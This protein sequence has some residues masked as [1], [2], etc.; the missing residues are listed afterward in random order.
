M[1]GKDGA[2]VNKEALATTQQR[3]GL[4]RVT[5]DSR[6]LP[7]QKGQGSLP[8]PTSHAP[9]PGAASTPREEGLLPVTQRYP[10][11]ACQA[12]GF[13]PVGHLFPV[14]H[15]AASGFPRFDMLQGQYLRRLDWPR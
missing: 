13:Y 6:S 5:S 12:V 8:P 9:G 14:S 15:W 3:A 7:P 4:T 11:Y 1:L 2:P 10:P